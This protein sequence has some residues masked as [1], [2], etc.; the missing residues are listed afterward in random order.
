MFT[1]ILNSGVLKYFVIIAIG[2]VFI[3]TISTISNPNQDTTTKEALH[4]NDGAS[5]VVL[6][7]TKDSEKTMEEITF[8]FTKKSEVKKEEQIEFNN[9]DLTNEELFEQNLLDVSKLNRVVLILVVLII[10][11]TVVIVKRGSKW[12]NM[13]T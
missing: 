8:D 6:D 4:G 11:I 3:Y 12:K 1:K 13:E 2:F 7:F 9:Y 5:L 10:I